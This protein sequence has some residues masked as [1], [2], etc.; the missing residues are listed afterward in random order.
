M[1]NPLAIV[2]HVSGAEIASGQSVAVDIGALRKMVRL[3]LDV[4]VVTG[5]FTSG[6]GLNLTVETGPNASGPWRSLAG[7][8]TQIVHAQ[9]RNFGE[10]DQFVR[11]NWTVTG[12]TPSFTFS[13]AGDAHVL[14]VTPSEL[15]DVSIAAKAFATFDQSKKLARCLRATDDA[16]GYLR[17]RYTLPLVSW[18]S[19]LTDNVGHLAV[20]GG[21]NA[22][23]FQPEGPDAMLLDNRNAAVR[24][25]KDVGAGN[26]TPNIV[27][28]TPTKRGAAPRIF[29]RD[30]TT[31][32]NGSCE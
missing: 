23:G 18:S 3:R 6:Q 17:R 11:L 29:T 20:W 5:S 8:N 15:A 1:A 4:T 28:S 24:W 31:D 22:R 13:V 2:L 26:V 30:R 19:D 27:D 12:T 16:D 9:E 25:L 10:C 21:I 32:E 14:Y 7:W